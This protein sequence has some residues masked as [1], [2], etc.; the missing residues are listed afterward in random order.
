MS[1]HCG[2]T[3]AQSALRSVAEI[4]LACRVVGIQLFLLLLP[5]IITAYR[6]FSEISEKINE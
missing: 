4:P 6:Q 1:Q 2:V 3:R 5:Y